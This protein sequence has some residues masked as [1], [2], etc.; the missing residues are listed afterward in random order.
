MKGKIKYLG[1]CAFIG[2]KVTGCLWMRCLFLVALGIGLMVM[3]SGCSESSFGL[4]QKKELGRGR[5]IAV[6]ADKYISSG[7]CRSCH[8]SN[9]ASWYGSF[10]RTMTQV[11]NSSTVV[12]PIGKEFS[13]LGETSRLKVRGGDVWFQMD[14]SPS[15]RH[16][17][18]MRLSM[19]TGSHHMQVYWYS[20]G[21]GRKL[22]QIPFIYL[23]QEDEWIPRGASFLSPPKPGLQTALPGAWNMAC[24]KCHTTQGKPRS[25]NWGSPNLPMTDFSFDSRVAEFGIAC[26]ACHGPGED[27]VRVNRDPI[28][29]YRYHLDEGADETIVHPARLSH[30]ASSQVCGQC[31]GVMEFYDK[32]G[33][34]EWMNYGYPYRPGDVLSETKLVVQF[35]DK[36]HPR[37]RSLVRQNPEFWKQKFWSDGMVRVS[38]REY[39]GLI[40]SPCFQEGELS[41]LSCHS[42][43][44]SLDDPRPLSL[45]AVDQ[46]KP[47]MDGDQ[48]CLQCHKSFR[49]NVSEHTHHK[50]QSTGSRCYNC[51][52]P[53]TTYGLLKAIRSHQ[54]D[55]PTVA[56]S[57]KTGRP[58]AC[59]QCHLDKTL[60][61]AA[62]Y[63]EDWYG[64]SKPELNREQQSVA[65]SLL[66]LLR[67]DAG[68][69]ALMAWSMGWQSARQVS[70]AD[71][72]PPFLGQLLEDPY[73]AVRFIAAR[74]LRQSKAFAKIEYKFF[75]SPE[76]RAVSHQQ[77]LNIWNALPLPRNQSGR[78]ELLIDHAGRVRGELFNRLLLQR[79]DQLVS[80]AE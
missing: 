2:Y 66:W 24:I 40:E 25:P 11:A 49:Q 70:G 13:F 1:G 10:H 76:K 29:R 26:E 50:A 57:L 73:D 6:P 3:G 34:E 65:A 28:R 27:H 61:W 5:P 9:Y 18:E 46:L 54:I 14:A 21:Q 78:E 67:G 56:A 58:N 68:Q 80:L 32:D 36:E 33:F 16:P 22:G 37:V 53:Y 38:G 41:C 23:I 59:N 30:E 79:D 71:W 60:E 74:S 77:V 17:V 47:K 75:G 39:N 63:M 31:H 45:W 44:K 64:Q 12:A 51:H 42:M 4:K 15:R 69:R 62:A 19:I 20:I 7:T 48:A 72:M 35:D 55:I 8:P 52:M 43:H